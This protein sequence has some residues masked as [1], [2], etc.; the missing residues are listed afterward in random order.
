MFFVFKI[1]GKNNITFGRGLYI[2]IQNRTLYGSNETNSST[3][4]VDEKLIKNYNTEYTE[5]LKKPL[6]NSDE[7]IRQFKYTIIKNK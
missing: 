7:D 6:E 4:S 1:V 5:F 2:F 3:L